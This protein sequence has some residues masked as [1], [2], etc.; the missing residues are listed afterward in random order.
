MRNLVTSS[1]VCA[2]LLFA[3]PSPARAQISF[4]I[5]IGQ[6]PPPRA[7]V[8]PNRPGRDY[9]W[10]EGY[11][12]PE[13]RRYKWR[14]GYWTRPPVAGAYWVE[15]YYYRGKYFEGYWEGPHGRRL[16]DDHRSE[17]P[18]EDRRDERRRDD[19]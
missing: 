3:A 8:V 12:Y 10:V 9:V 14:D 19:R 1:A 18:R 4:G 7:Y 15:P 17:R 13:G 16:K 2:L 11:W 5:T 6:P